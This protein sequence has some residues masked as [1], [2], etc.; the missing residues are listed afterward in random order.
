VALVNPRQKAET[1]LAI[2]ET[3]IKG[4]RYLL[5]RNEEEAQKGRRATAAILANLGRKLDQ[6]TKHW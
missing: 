3:T 6:A 4:R 1:R 5:S 2:N